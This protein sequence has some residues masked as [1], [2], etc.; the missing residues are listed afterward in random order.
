MIKDYVRTNTYRKAILENA[1]DFK[2]KVVVD[3]GCGTCILSFFCIQAG[4]KKGY[5]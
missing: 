2:G 3:V 4:A 1:A 5:L